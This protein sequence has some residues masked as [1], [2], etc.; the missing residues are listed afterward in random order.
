[1]PWD[2]SANQPGLRRRF[3]VLDE[4]AFALGFMDVTAVREPIVI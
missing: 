4:V 3:G 2:P 1:M